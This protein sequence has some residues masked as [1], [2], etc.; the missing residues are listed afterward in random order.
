MSHKT[1]QNNGKERLSQYL[2]K[3][4]SNVVV[5]LEKTEVQHQIPDCNLQKGNKRLLL[6]YSSSLLAILSIAGSCIWLYLFFL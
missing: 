3:H 1:L 2:T 6:L 4:C 5:Y